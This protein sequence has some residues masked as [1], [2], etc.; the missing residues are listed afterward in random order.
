MY[1]E[2]NYT[3]KENESLRTTFHLEYK[4]PLFEPK[5]KKYLIHFGGTVN[6]DYDHFGKTLK[7]NGFTGFGIDF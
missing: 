7:I 1:G 5:H 6:P 3:K 2:T 4:I